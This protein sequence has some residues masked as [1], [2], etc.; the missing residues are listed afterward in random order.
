MSGRI[1]WRP[2]RV[3]RWAGVALSAP[4]LAV[5]VALFFIPFLNSFFSS[6]RR[7]GQW[8]LA[9]YHTVSRLYLEDVFFTVGVSL[10]AL[11]ATLLVAVTLAGYLR[12]RPNRVVEFLFKVPLFVPFVV[13]GHAMRVFLA[14]HGL[15]NSALAQVGLVNLDTPP[16]IAF[17]WVGI[18]VALTWKNMAMAL[19]LVAGAFRGVGEEYLEAARNAG[20]TGWRL[21]KDIL[22]P[23]S[24]GS[25]AVT[26]VLIFT[27]M[28]ASFSIPLMIGSGQDAQMLMIDIYYRIVY[29][30]DYGV[31]N[32]LG[33]LSYLG[34]AGAAIYYVRTV[35]T[36]GR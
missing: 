22:L 32:A 30:Q 12:L 23:M 25:V 17:S 7:E 21:V 8:T 6:F 9:N 31:A 18:V 28:M 34:A 13:V 19:L 33:V 14:P 4:A 35:K 29:Q 1:T 3:E 15:L 20:A 2:D 27:S 11:A 24:A 10:A 36:S 16:S 5:V 26:A